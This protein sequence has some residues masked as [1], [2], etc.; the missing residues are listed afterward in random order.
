[1]YIFSPGRAS[2]ASVKS[3]EL[4]P[5]ETSYTLEWVT[6]SITPVRAFKLQYRPEGKTSW[7]Q[8]ID[9]STPIDNGDH[10]FAGKF[11]F[12]KLLP[13]SSYEVRISSL[14][15]YGYSQYS[16]PFTFGT[17]GAGNE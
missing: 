2:P 5:E 9:V 15:E 7:S 1:M 13:A 6:E 3:P 4:G 14:N 17:K 10:F 11:K 12:E 8:D 16:E